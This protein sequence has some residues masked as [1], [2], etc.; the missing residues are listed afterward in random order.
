MG[1]VPLQPGQ[2]KIYQMTKFCLKRLQVLILEAQRYAFIG[3]TPH[4]VFLKR[5]LRI[6]VRVE[7]TAVRNE[8]KRLK[9]WRDIT[10]I[11]FFLYKIKVKPPLIETAKFLSRELRHINILFLN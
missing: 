4:N 2:S 7:N 6:E 1:Q 11:T 3:I 10:E 8:V 9:F 5:Q